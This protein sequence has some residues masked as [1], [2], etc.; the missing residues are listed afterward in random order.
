[1]T[2]LVWDTVGQRFYE[3][4]VDRGVLYIPNGSG[5]YDTGFAWNGLTT[6]TETPDG[7]SATPQYAD[8]IQYLNLISAETLGGTIEAFTYPDQFGQCD[9][10]ANPNTGVN[11][12]QQARKSFGLSYRT[13][14]GN[15]LVGTAFGYKIHLLYGA[16]AQPSEKAFATINDSPEALAF[17]WGFTTAPVSVTGLKPTALLTVDTSKALASGVTALEAALYGGSSTTPRLP[18]PDEVIAMFAGA[19]TP[20]TTLP[21]TYVSGTHTLTVPSVTGVVY[22]RTDTGAIV[23]PASTIV[24]TTGQTIVLKATP[25]AGYVFTAGSD[26]DWST[27]YS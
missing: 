17:S 20:V 24:L 11:V 6:V 12:T 3:T 9:G 14:L 10:T 25:A 18:L 5:V 2:A 19:L 27:P 23:A 21:P 15:D 26:D 22:R 7:A 8:N 16:T 1:M 13:L 4:G